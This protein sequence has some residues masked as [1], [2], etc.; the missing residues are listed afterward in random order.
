MQIQQEEALTYPAP[1]Q[2]ANI[3]KQLEVRMAGNVASRTYRPDKKNIG[4]V[5]QNNF[6]P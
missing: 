5:T 3:T 1:P 6:I 4:S 2:T